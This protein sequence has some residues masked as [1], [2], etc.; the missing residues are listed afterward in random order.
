[1]GV[2]EQVT[3]MMNQGKSDDEIAGDLQQKGVSPKEI[4]DAFS[5]A[6]IKSAVSDMEE[7]SPDYEE[8]LPVQSN[9]EM[10]SE[11]VYMPSPSEAEEGE[12]YPQQQSPDYSQQGGDY[13]QGG[14]EGY[15]SAGGS[16]VDTMIEI[17]EQVFS[18][19]IKDV[20]KKTDDLTEF[21]ALSQIRVD[22]ISERM[23]RIEA[24]IDKL[25][26]SILEKI[27]SYGDNLESIK[28]EMSMMQDSFGKVVNQAVKGAHHGISAEHEKAP[29]EKLKKFQK[30]R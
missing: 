19:K 23:K 8:N 27:G 3:Q 6:R 4:N 13:A 7:T 15:A 26:V 28:K 9:A 21:K 17:S 16:S 20:Q 5:Q 29:H 30:S 14:Y 25:Q 10:P 12:Y 24:I 22:N 1:M 18:E 2:L 11:D